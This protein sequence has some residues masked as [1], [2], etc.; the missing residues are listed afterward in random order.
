[1]KVFSLD[2]CDNEMRLQ[3]DA[4]KQQNLEQVLFSINIIKII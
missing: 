3:V 4:T 2:Y 1:M